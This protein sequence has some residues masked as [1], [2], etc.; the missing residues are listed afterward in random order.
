M[1]EEQRAERMQALF[2]LVRVGLGLFAFGF[3][4]FFIISSTTSHMLEHIVAVS[5]F[6]L[7]GIGGIVLGL[8]IL[9]FAGILRIGRLF[10]NR[11]TRMATVVLLCAAV[12]APAVWPLLWVTRASG[13]VHPGA[14]AYEYGVEDRYYQSGLRLRF[15]S[16]WSRVV[17]TFSESELLVPPQAKWLGNGRAVL[18]EFRLREY[19]DSLHY[20]GS[21]KLLYDF[22]GGRT[23][24]VS[25]LPLGP[26]GQPEW[27]NR[28]RMSEDELKKL[29]T[30][31]ER[32]A[33]AIPLVGPSFLT[34]ATE[35]WN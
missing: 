23:A 13:S 10:Q 35:S 26:W 6:M 28:Q 2:R 4:L 33:Q 34:A 24:I 32:V 20:D 19:H 11:L 9:L 21:A 3:L 5:I 16:C 31:I 29:I 12:T 27:R 14:C 30:D 8:V 15:S 17:Y 18:L 22:E 7:V 25:Q 1:P